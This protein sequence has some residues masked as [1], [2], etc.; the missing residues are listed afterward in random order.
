METFA[1]MQAKE[2]KKKTNKT[3]KY[4]IPYLPRE[5]DNLAT[6]TWHFPLGN[7]ASAW[8]AVALEDILCKHA[9]SSAFTSE[10]MSFDME[11]PFVQFGSAVLIILLPKILPTLSYWWGWNVG[12]TVLMLCQCCWAIAKAL[13]GYQHLS[14][15]QCKVQQGEDCCEG[16]ELQLS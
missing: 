6:S 9:I 15:H 13:V 16:N 11:Y 4:F 1:C 8:V 3:P 5:S 14:N 2:K 12:G 7:K 10:L